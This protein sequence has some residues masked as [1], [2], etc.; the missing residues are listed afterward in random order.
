[1]EEIQKSPIVICI[2]NND[3]EQAIRGA[4]AVLDGG[5]RV[6]EVTLTTPEAP[7][8]IRELSKDSRAIVGAGTLLT[9]EDVQTVVEAGGRFGMSPVS[10]PAVIEAAKK[11]GLFFAPGTSTPSEILRAHQLGAD[12]VKVFPIGPLGGAGF[13]RAVRGPLP[14]IPLL[15]TNGVSLENLSDFFKAGVFAVGVGREI[16]DPEALQTGE[17]E[18]ITEKAIQFA[19]A[20]PD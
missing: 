9:P 20:L 15:P 7:R 12:V 11:A 10:D 4:R 19:E 6:I 17:Y 5:L 18:R 1:M 13:I 8:I 3:A 16:L 2:R 14:D